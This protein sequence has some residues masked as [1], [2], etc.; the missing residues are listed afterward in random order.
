MTQ[1]VIAWLQLA[2]KDDHQFVIITETR[3][4]SGFYSAGNKLSAKH[5]DKQ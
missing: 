4:L 1:F 5:T 3:C 2:E